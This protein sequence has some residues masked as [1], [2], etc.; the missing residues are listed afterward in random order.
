MGLDS[1]GNPGNN[2]DINP[3]RSL[4][5]DQLNLA[6]S[7]NIHGNLANHPLNQS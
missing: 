2:R 6:N 4:E 5:F 1:C 7:D 3:Y